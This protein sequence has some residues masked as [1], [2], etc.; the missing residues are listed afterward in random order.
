MFCP[1]EAAHAR[2]EALLVI[3]ILPSDSM[4]S[5]SGQLAQER[6]QTACVA[7][8]KRMNRVHLGVIVRQPLQEGGAIET[9]QVVLPSKLSEDALCVACDVAEVQTKCKHGPRYST[10]T[11]VRVL[12]E[13]AA[14][15]S[16]ARAPR[17]PRHP[18]MGS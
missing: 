9:L 5:L 11:R 18:K 1:V 14:V 6:A 16:S 7:L 2:S 8:P 15:E 4:I 13:S 17:P 10:L 12:V 3:E